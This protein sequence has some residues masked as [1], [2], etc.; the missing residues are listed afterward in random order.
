MP[1][2]EPSASE[3]SEDISTLSNFEPGQRPTKSEVCEESEISEVSLEGLV[4]NVKE[5]VRLRMDF[6]DRCIVCGFRGR[7]DFQANQFDGSWGL[8][9]G[10]CGRKLEQKLSEV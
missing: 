1:K 6:Q 8:L 10:N 2:K 4:P 9:C 7:M 5:L 3:V